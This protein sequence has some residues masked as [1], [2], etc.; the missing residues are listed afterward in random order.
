MCNAEKNRLL[1]VLVD[2][3][4]RLQ[5]RRTNVGIHRNLPFPLTVRAAPAFASIASPLLAG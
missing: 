2:A 4:I 3:G 5:V 1:K